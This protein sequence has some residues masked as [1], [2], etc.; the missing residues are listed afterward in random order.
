M[1]GFKQLWT[2]PGLHGGVRVQ[3][4]KPDGH[5]RSQTPAAQWV[6]FPPS[7]GS[8]AEHVWSLSQLLFQGPHIPQLASSGEGT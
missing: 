4:A 7:G 1:S 8:Q 6:I 5:E 2:G 3:S